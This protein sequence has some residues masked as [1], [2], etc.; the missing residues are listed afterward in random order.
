MNVLHIGNEQTWRGGENQ[1][2]LLIKGLK[3]HFGVNNFVAYP[4]NSP[5]LKNLS[6]VAEP[7]ALP[8]RSALDMRSIWKLVRFCQKNRIDLIDAQ[9]SG[10]HSLG[11]WVKKFCPGVKL[12]VHRRVDNPIQ[13]S[14]ISHRKYRHQK[15]NHYIAVSECI[16]RILLATGVEDNKVKV[17]H[18]AIDVGPYEH[19][20]HHQSRLKIL[21]RLNSRREVNHQLDSRVFLFGNASAL[22]DQKGTDVLLRAV[23]LLK[24]QGRSFHCV[25]AGDGYLRKSLEQ[26]ARQLDILNEVTFIG[27]IDNVP[28]LLSALDV[29]AMPSNNEG[30]GSL[31][32]EGLLSGCYVVA[33][34][35][36]GIPEVITNERVGKLSPKGDAEKLAENILWAKEHHRRSHFGREHVL[37]H[38]GF[39]QLLEKTYSVF[40]HAL[41]EQN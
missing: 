17:I 13:N 35:V 24:N 3:T 33:T 25:V 31:I 2:L 18:D 27:F 23:R 19:L 34:S 37:N 29:L 15:V 14:F 38:F 39:D 9:S 30:F 4:Q 36:G 5:G 22:T 1:A 12:I 20:D 7:L 16:R 21:A 32:L 26:L 11:L 8:S 6:A 28:E 41:K 40:L 10:G